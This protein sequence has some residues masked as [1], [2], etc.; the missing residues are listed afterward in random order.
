MTQ[1]HLDGKTINDNDWMIPVLKEQ[2]LPKDVLNNPELYA[3][4]KFTR[5]TTYE[6]NE[7]WAR[8]LGVENESWYQKISNLSK[9]FG[10]R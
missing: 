6:S 4:V 2:V 5:I 3:F 8:K 9:E 10:G 1:K 7:I